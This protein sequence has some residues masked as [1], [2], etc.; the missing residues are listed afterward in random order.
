VQPSGALW[1]EKMMPSAGPHSLMQSRSA[2][3]EP[4]PQMKSGSL[5]MQSA[6]G[7][8]TQRRVEGSHWM[9]E[10]QHALPQ[11]APGLGQEVPTAPGRSTGHP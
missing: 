5:Q 1:H 7:S 4:S 8:A 11:S 10:E 3:H 2:V 9:G 6:S